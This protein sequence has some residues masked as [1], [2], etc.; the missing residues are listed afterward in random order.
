[1][2]VEGVPVEIRE[3]NTGQVTLS[4]DK[5]APSGASIRYRIGE[6]SERAKESNIGSKGTDG[7]CRDYDYD[8]GTL[9][10]S[11][12]TSAT[13]SIRTFADTCVS[14]G[15]EEVYI[16]LFD[17]VKIDLGADTATVILRNVHSE[18]GFELEEKAEISV[19][20]GGTA[21]LKLVRNLSEPGQRVA[22]SVEVSL[23]SGGG[24]VAGDD[25]ETGPKT[26]SFSANQSSRTVSFR[27]LN[28]DEHG[29][30]DEYFNAQLANPVGARLKTS[31]D[32]LKIDIEDTDEV[33]VP[34]EIRVS[35]RAITPTVNEGETAV[36]E[37]AVEEADGRRLDQDFRVL[38]YM[39]RANDGPIH[40]TDYEAR[41]EWLTFG[42]AA[43]QSR[44]IRIETH[45]TQENKGS[46]T[47]LCRIG[48]DPT[49]NTRYDYSGTYAV[50]V[51][52]NSGQVDILNMNVSDQTDD[53]SRGPIWAYD[54]TVAE[55]SRSVSIDLNL[56]GEL[57]DPL[58]GS[59]KAPLVV[60]WRTTSQPD[61]ATAE[62]GT[63]YTSRSGT[64]TFRVGETTSFPISVP[65]RCDNAAEND[66][67]FYISA[68]GTRESGQT[69]GKLSTVKVTISSEYRRCG[70]TPDVISI[71]DSSAVEGEEMEFT[72]SVSRTFRTDITVEYATSNRTARAG[73]DYTATT[74]TVTITRSSSSATFTVATLE[75][76]A[77]DEAETFR[78]RLSDAMTGGVGLEFADDEA[79]GTIIDGMPI[80][81]EFAGVPTTH[82]GAPFAME[83]RLTA[84]LTATAAELESALTGTGRTVTAE[85]ASATRWTLTVT[86]E[87]VGNVTV[88]L[89]HTALSG[90][91]ERRIK[92]VE[93][94]TV[95]GRATASIGDAEAMESDGSMR[96]TVELDQP[97]RAE[98]SLRW[99]TAD[100][101]AVNGQDY[102]SGSGRVEFAGGSLQATIVVK[103]FRTTQLEDDETFTVT[104]SSPRGRVVVDADEGVATGTIKD[105]SVGAQFEAPESP[106]TDGSNFTVGLRFHPAVENI[107]LN[108]LRGELSVT[109]G[110]RVVSVTRKTAGDHQNFI[111]T[112]DP[113]GQKHVEIVLPRNA[114]VG[115]RRMQYE[116]RLMILGPVTISINDVE[117]TEGTDSTLQFSVSLSQEPLQTVTVDY[118]TEDD[119]AMAGSDYTTVSGTL[120]FGENDTSKPIDVPILDDEVDENEEQ[121]KVKLSNPEGAT[122]GDDEGIGKIKNHDALP[123]ALIARFG[124][125]TASHVV[126]QVEARIGRPPDRMGFDFSLGAGWTQRMGNAQGSLPGHDLAIGSAGSRMDGRSNTMRRGRLSG[127]MMNGTGSGMDD[128]PLAGAS[129]ALNRETG[130]GIISVWSQSAQSSFAGQQGHI[131]LGGDVRTTMVGADYSKGRLMTGVAL[132]RSLGT[133]NYA[134]V[135]RG[136]VTSALTGLYPW[137]G[138]QATDRVTVWGVAGYGAGGMVLTTGAGRQD[139]PVSMTMMAAGTR[140]ELTTGPGL[141]LA[142]KADA[143]WVGTAIAGSEGPNGNLAAA[144]AAVTRMR[145]GIEGSRSYTLMGRLALKPIVELGLRRD[146]G[147]AENGAGVDVGG[148]VVVADAASGLA[149]DVRVRMVVV[150]QAEEFSERGVAVTFSYNPTSTPRGLSA[151]IAPAWGGNA[152]GSANTLWGGE[153]MNGIGYGDRGGRLDGEVGYGLPVGRFVGT[154]RFGFST[155]SHGRIYRLGYGLAAAEA[156]DVRFELGVDVQRSESVHLPGANHGG[157]GRTTVSW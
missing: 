104:L 113:D 50:T 120:T 59:D 136:E 4:L 145:T 127:P 24:A 137:I 106:R 125:A 9:S 155:A 47:F 138:Y 72:V 35:L 2:R 134:G 3:G 55:R 12:R 82:E 94:V 97:T 45:Q 154:P 107:D 18:I 96:F 71:A 99:A 33:P 123:I 5:R 56:N 57:P 42:R 147:D 20:E 140:G 76:D 58:S 78:V 36:C 87:G 39:Q 100:V 115:D 34:H 130:G 31:Y 114:E 150:H 51:V 64:H 86:P 38:F 98:V 83:L 41:E 122:L 156:G 28:D 22:A 16:Q 10:L 135:S 124:R 118:T 101:T 1:M 68:R 17:P 49:E 79:I 65:I 60:L 117:A 103:I 151:R 108:D 93:S 111:V 29:E 128:D 109:G 53:T 84:E 32:S 61:D 46:L 48:S 23:Q 141:R 77:R 139:S 157:M 44:Q 116:I 143:L 11:R 63:D 102:E 129:F 146:G 19:R 153:V 85:K 92:A 52:E 7:E 149:V 26:V 89:D 8:E 74:G 6:S 54:Q 70:S 13:L 110:A 21:R 90:A 148:G 75:D 95:F 132:A 144:Q 37:V 119:T 15:T 27:V 30:D 152:T 73:R 142:V 81:A 40:G 43:S 67:H 62:A 121:F 112:I 131:A 126:E 133:G 80:E 14:E 25:H 69:I 66:E 105:D 88:G 91:D